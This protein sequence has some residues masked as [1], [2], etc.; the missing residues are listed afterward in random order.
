MTDNDRDFKLSA[1]ERFC[2]ELQKVVTD[3]GGR[4]QFFDN[5]SQS[6]PAFV[7]TFGMGDPQVREILSKCL[8]NLAFR[9]QLQNLIKDEESAEF[10][11]NF[12]KSWDLWRTFSDSDPN[13]IS[14]S[15]DV[16]IVDTLVNGAIPSR[17]NDIFRCTSS[18]NLDS[19]SETLR[20]RSCV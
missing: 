7:D 4:E 6:P 15:L 17:V 16:S 11:D 9:A 19:F 12:M 1:V 14:Y 18:L 20:V 2:M 13:W 3:L 8:D 10:I 5:L